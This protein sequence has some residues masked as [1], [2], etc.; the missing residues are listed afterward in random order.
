M[1]RFIHS[2]RRATLLAAGAL[3]LS[4]CSSTGP[5]SRIAAATT[6]P[7]E[8]AA[9]SRASLASLY[10]RYPKARQLGAKAKGILV[11]P[12]V[13]KGGLMVGGLGGTGALIDPDGKIREFYQ[14]SG[15]SYGLQAGI[16]KYSYAL[17]LMDDQARSYLRQSGGWQVGS[18]PGLVI[19]DEAAGASMSV[20]SINRGTYAI[21]YHERGL[22][23]GLGLQG[24]HVARFIP[25][26]P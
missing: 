11:F 3:V 21:L 18:A 13:T 4:Q 1:R 22:M 19:V 10:R 25:D 24:S 2:L 14:T 23:G 16:Q 12:S 5:A 17:F 9:D 26:Q 15:L 8:L 20:G 7:R 6:N